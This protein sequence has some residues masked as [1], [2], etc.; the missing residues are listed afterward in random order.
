MAS[1]LNA[2]PLLEKVLEQGSS[3]LLL[4][5]TNSPITRTNGILAPM[6]GLDSL[7]AEDIE[8]FLSQILKAD[9]KDIF[10]VNKE[11]DFS[12]ALGNKARFRVNAFFQ[13]G[14]PSVAMRTIPMV[15]PSLDQLNLP[16][17]L[18]HLCNLKQ[19]LVLVVGPTGHGKSTTIAAMIEKINNDR[20]AYSHYRR[21][22]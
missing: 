10:D 9:Q 20:R 18:D 16:E 21:P 6:P 8:F 15:V 4:S 14:Y 22:Y 3:D 19:G 13:R 5:V 1:K 11:I 12:V 7:T 2:T 17:T